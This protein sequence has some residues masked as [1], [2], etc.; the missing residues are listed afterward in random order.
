MAEID[1]YEPVKQFLQA[2]GYVVK[3]EITDCDVVAVRGDEAPVIVE[4]KDS[5]NLALILQAVDR[6]R[7]TGSVYVA[8]RVGKGKSATWRSRHKQVISLFRRLGAGILTVS[9]RGKVVAV[10]DPAPY[11]PR[12][13]VRRRKRM[14]KEFTER[15]GD[16]HAGGSASGERFTA[17]RQDALRCGV[18]LADNGMLKVSEIRERTGVDRA[19]AIFIDNHYG[20]FDRVKRGYYEL[21]PKGQ[22][23]VQ[24]WRAL[25]ANTAAD[26]GDSPPR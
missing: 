22:E 8:F 26:I 9:T 14:L 1:L 20:W 13:D 4:L 21:S 11:T 6:L 2:Q 15:V 19:G 18:E 25:V 24:R 3:G 17:Y 10:L 23:D 5:L 12:A 16:P 7:I